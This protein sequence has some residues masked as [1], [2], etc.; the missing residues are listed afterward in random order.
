MNQNAVGAC[1]KLKMVIDGQIP[2]DVWGIM[3]GVPGV[4]QWEGDNEHGN[5]VTLE[6]QP[7]GLS[8]GKHKLAFWADETPIIWWVKVCDLESEG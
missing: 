4:Y 1:D 8:A 3:S 7:P 5:R 2:S 6:F